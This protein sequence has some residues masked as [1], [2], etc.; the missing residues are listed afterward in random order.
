MNCTNAF[1]TRYGGVFAC[2]MREIDRV[3]WSPQRD[4]IEVLVDEIAKLRA[5]RAQATVVSEKDIVR[6][7]ISE[8]FKD[9]NALLDRTQEREVKEEKEAEIEAKIKGESP[10]ALV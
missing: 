10:H 7:E 6:K 1:K 4:Q 9:F 5:E 2:M 3:C 8:S